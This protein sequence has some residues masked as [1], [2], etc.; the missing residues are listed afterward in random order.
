MLMTMQVHSAS[1][2]AFVLYKKNDGKEVHRYYSNTLGGK[3][4]KQDEALG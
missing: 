4:G 3:Y 2:K 1:A